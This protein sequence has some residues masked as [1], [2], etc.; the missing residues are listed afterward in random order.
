MT[1]TL[2]NYPESQDSWDNLPKEFTDYLNFL[3]EIR[4]ETAKQQVVDPLYPTY[5]YEWEL[6]EEI[7]L[8]TILNYWNDVNKELPDPNVIF[9]EINDCFAET[10]YDDYVSSYYSY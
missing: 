3:D 7:P 2:L 4:I 5:D 10:S 1:R 8:I 6:D 9:E